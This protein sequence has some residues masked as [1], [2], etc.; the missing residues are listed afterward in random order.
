MRR[1]ISAA[2]LL[3][4]G[5]SVTAQAAQEAA[6]RETVAKLLRWEQSVKPSG[7]YRE[8]LG[9]ELAALISDELLCLLQGASDLRERETRA[10]PDE[11]P[12]YVEGRLWMPNPWD[13]VLGTE[14]ASVH[15]VPGHP[16]RLRV[17]VS[18]DYGEGGHEVGHYLVEGGRILDVDAGGNC[19]FC[20]ESSLRSDI[21]RS[22]R[23]SGDPAA[24]R[25]QALAR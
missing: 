4:C 6:A 14:I 22:L 11:K 9:A 1:V 16:A 10:S 7:F 21:Y 8:Q 19:P 3:G 5:L 20:Q 13:P 15:P 25:C 24:Q 23:G 17:D 2:L 12:S 18:V